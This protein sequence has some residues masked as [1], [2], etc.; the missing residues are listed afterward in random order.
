MEQRPLT[1]CGVR[2]RGVEFPL[3]GQFSPPHPVTLTDEEKSAI[4]VPAAAK[5][6]VW[7]YP[8]AGWTAVDGGERADTAAAVSFLSVGGFVYLDERNR[9]LHATTLVP[10]AL[11]AGGLQFRAPAPWVAEWTATLMRHGRFQRIT[12]K[13]L[14]DLGAHHFCWLRPGE[15]IPSADGTPCAEQ[16]N[17]PHGGFAYL[18]HDDVLSSTPEQRVLDRYFACASGDEYVPMDEHEAAIAAEG[19]AALAS[20]FGL[21]SELAALNALHDAAASQPTGEAHDA[22]TRQIDALELQLSAAT[23]CVACFDADKDTILNCGHVALC[24]HCATRVTSCPLCRCAITE[25]RACFR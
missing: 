15:V 20:S 17:V 16:P 13:A 1:R 11:E 24:R 8:V 12:I 9:A 22:L 6:F 14:N 5:R 10:S 21:V 23:K 19:H 18:F 4:G 7:S 2:C 25:R 3:V